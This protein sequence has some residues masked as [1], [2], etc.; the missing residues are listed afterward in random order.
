[1]TTAS[2]A[3]GSAK[4]APAT[5]A[6]FRA[7]TRTRAA[8]PHVVMIVVM[9]GVMV[10]PWGALASLAGAAILVATSVCCA[11]IAR[12]N[13]AFRTHIVDLWAMAVLI[14][15]LLPGAGSQAI[16]TMGTA[17]GGGSPMPLAAGSGIALVPVILVWAAVRAILA[18]FST[19]HLHDAVT[20]VITATG[21]V[22]M[23]A[24]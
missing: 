8:W 12:G 11:P 2:S 14:L 17:V 4:R 1:M 18:A 5:S 10:G 6:L 23:I 13:D 9:V 16:M 15:A 20:A 21:L 3:H 7:I 19:R 22:A 24:L